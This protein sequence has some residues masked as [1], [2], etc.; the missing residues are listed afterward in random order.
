MCCLACSN[1]SI[2]YGLCLLL[3]RG[4]EEK[5][6]QFVLCTFHIAFH[7][8][9]VIKSATKMPPLNVTGI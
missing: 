9:R 1:K 2:C 8:L 3:N 4:G 6:E 7:I 5:E